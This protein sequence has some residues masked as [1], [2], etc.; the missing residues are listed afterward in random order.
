[1]GVPTSGFEP[2]R[3]QS[4]CKIWSG[5]RGVGGEGVVGWVLGQFSYVLVCFS[6]VAEFLYLRYSASFTADPLIGVVVMG[7]VCSGAGYG[8]L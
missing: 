8:R 5:I 4:T 7:R 1:M 6:F 3:A 2:L